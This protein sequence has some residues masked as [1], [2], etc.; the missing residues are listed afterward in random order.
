MKP[1]LLFQTFIETGKRW[2]LTCFI[3][4]GVFSV[5]LATTT[6]SLTYRIEQTITAS[7]GTFAPFW[8][9]NQHFGTISPQPF[10]TTLRAT[11]AGRTTFTS[12]ISLDY[13]LD[14]VLN[15]SNGNASSGWIQQ[16]FLHARWLIFD[17][18]IG[19]Q[20]NQQLLTDRFL[21]SGALIFS[22]N[23][24][25]M[26]QIS[27]G[28]DR[29]TSVPFTRNQIKFRGGI[30]HGWFTDNTY[31]P[32][33]WLHHKYFHLRLADRWPV[34]IQLGLDHMAQWGGKLPD[35]P[36]QDFTLLAFKNIFLAR[37]GGDASSVYEKNNA[38]GNHILSE[39]ARLEVEIGNF[40]GSLYWQN[41]IEDSPFRLAPWKMM[42]REDGLWGLSVENKTL[43]VF[44]KVV[45]ERINTTDQSGYIHDKDGIIYGGQDSYF[46]NGTYLNDWAFHRRSI[47]NPL[48]LSPLYNPDDSFRIQHIWINAYHLGFSGQT[49]N[50]TY[51]FMGTQVKHY[52][53]KLQ[54]FTTNN[55]WMAELT[56]KI[57]SVGL[58]V[59]LAGDTGLFPGNTTGIQFVFKKSGTLFQP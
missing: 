2:L 56:R 28:I 4:S 9:Q 17:L 55:Y 31:V 36:A 46:T 1:E 41:I 19:S 48:I 43:P 16:L 11:F 40:I 24:R 45:F 22:P 3:S 42:N 37:S 8:L 38:M 33:I 51:R 12:T 34:R 23:S 44:Q 49:K 26:P 29:F 14:A 27:A 57:K 13:G 35:Q 21:S 5:I 50:W 30:T 15:A 52:N 58:S 39:H 53:L 10:S 32:D 59:R 54:P 7:D 47:G 20:E 6:D 25:P 18:T